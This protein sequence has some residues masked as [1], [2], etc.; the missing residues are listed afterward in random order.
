MRTSENFGLNLVEGD[1]IVNPLIQDVPNY[2]KIDATM[3]TNLN[4]VVGVANHLKAGTVH[5][6]VRVTG[7]ETPMIRFTA[8]ARFNTGDTFTVDTVQVSA[9]LVDGST[10]EDGA[11][12]IGSEVLCC[13]KGSLLTVYGV[14]NKATD[15]D[16][17]GGE[18]P[19][20]YATKNEVDTAQATATSAGEMVNSLTPRVDNIWDKWNNTYQELSINTKYKLS[21]NTSLLACFS[22][23]S[24]NLNGLYYVNCSVD[25]T[26]RYNELCNRIT[27]VTVTTGTNTITFKSTSTPIIS[28]IV[29]HGYVELAG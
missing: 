18:L 7:D 21:A 3:K 17:F 15:T 5:S 11:F 28:C 9:L 23:N 10:L 8:T 19:A 24:S 13:L 6:L 1:D 26:I 2:E 20:Y 14:R 16:R 4:C 27:G 12:I 29:L 25:G 22:H